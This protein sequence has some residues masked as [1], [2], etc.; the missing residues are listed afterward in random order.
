LSADSENGVQ[1]FRSAF[2][3]PDAVAR[4]TEGPPRVVPGY[5]SLHRMTGIL[6]AE[7]AQND[8][9]ILV[10]GAGGGLELKALAETYPTWRFVG[11]DPAEMMLE[12]AALTLGPLIE[13]VE[14]I[15]GY[16]DD[17]PAGPFDGATSLLTLHFL[18]AE[19]RLRTVLAVRER[20]RP[21]AAFVAAHGSF[22]QRNAEERALWLSRYAAFA[23][24]SG[25]DPEMVVKA[26]A[27]I[28]AGVSMLAPD[29]DE[30]IFRAA[31]FSELSLFYAAFNWRGWVARAPRLP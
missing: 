7:Q 4:Y 29:E 28:E 15:H 24:T 13:R 1:F 17:A 11:V 19:E 21:G 18:K 5:D 27:A 16:I 26:R 25:G 12:L 30:A 31:G 14:L 6:L 23:V 22:P 2:S 8:A 3:D 20:L 9:T 10:L